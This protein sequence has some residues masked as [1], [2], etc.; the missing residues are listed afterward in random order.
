M[1]RHYTLNYG[2]IAPIP[3]PHIPFSLINPND[4]DD[5]DNHNNDNSDNSNG[6]NDEDERMK[7]E[8]KLAEKKYNLIV[9]TEHAV[10]KFNHFDEYKHLKEIDNGASQTLY[11]K[12]EGELSSESTSD[13]YVELLVSALEMLHRCSEKFINVSVKLV[14]VERALRVPCVIVERYLHKP[15][16]HAHAQTIVCHVTKL[17]V[18][19]A[20][21]DD[22]KQLMA[23]DDKIIKLVVLVLKS[24]MDDSVKIEAMSL[25]SDLSKEQVLGWKDETMC[26][27]ISCLD[28]ENSRATRNCAI[29]ALGNIAAHEENKSRLVYY[30]NYEL[31]NKL[32]FLVSSGQNKNIRKDIV[33]VLANLSNAD[34]SPLLCNHPEF[35]NILVSQATDDTNK[36]AQR[37]ALK[38]LRRLSS[39]V[40]GNALGHKNLLKAL[41]KTLK[42][43]ENNVKYVV[44]ILKDQAS[45]PV[46]RNSLVNFPGLLDYLAL[47]SL[48]VQ[49]VKSNAIKVL[50]YLAYLDDG[51]TFTASET[52]LTALTTAAGLTTKKNAVARFAAMK[53]IKKLASREENRKSLEEKQSLLVSLRWATEKA[54]KKVVIA[55]TLTELL[56]PD[57]MRFTV[58]DA[59]DGQKSKKVNDEDL[60]D[61]ANATI[62]Q[63]TGKESND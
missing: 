44:S 24:D 20:K 52:V 9:A 61:L 35:L 27:L 57:G 15:K 26:V 13:T 59:I 51:L 21:A 30:N 46:N 37:S 17:L 33:G 42:G 16:Y 63:I 11:S 48:E 53:T 7:A 41:L 55:D 23:G 22:L 62:L 56:T 2:N 47:I 39:F 49:D 3:T 29:C 1:I 25:L 58:L 18:H 38:V 34:I 12:L 50:L 28:E 45:N 36:E 32:I 4:D 6:D 60:I 54:S 40:D 14:G 10:A 8:K 31:V 5:K 19:F 43:G